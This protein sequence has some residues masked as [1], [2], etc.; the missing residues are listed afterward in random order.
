MWGLAHLKWKDGAI[1]FDVEVGKFDVEGRSDPNE[2]AGPHTREWSALGDIGD[3]CLHLDRPDDAIDLEGARCRD[4]YRRVGHGSV[5]A[6]RL[7]PFESE[8]RFG[9]RLGPECH[10]LATVPRLN[11]RLKRGHDPL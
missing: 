9:V 5:H 10:A 11:T 3:P 1:A 2:V 7:D 6:R 4:V 8:N